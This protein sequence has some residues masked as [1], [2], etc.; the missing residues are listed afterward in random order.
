VSTIL[1]ALRRLE[2]EKQVQ[3]PRPLREQ[4]T[5]AAPTRRG[6]GW[7]AAMGAISAGVVVGALVFFLWPRLGAPDAAPSEA[8][9]AR[10]PASARVAPVRPPRAMPPPA[11]APGPAAR[12]ET[13]PGGG[14]ATLP[15]AALASR[16]EVVERMAPPARPPALPA[17]EPASP[18]PAVA[19]SPAPAPPVRSARRVTAPR[20]EAQ[21]EEGPRT[22]APAA[23]VVASAALPA[24]PAPVPRA[25]PAP[26]AEPVTARSD[27]PAAGSERS[28]PE[29]PSAPSKLVRTFVPGVLVVRTFW[30]PS[31][32]RRVAEIEVDGS[33]E[34][35]RLHEGDAVGPLVVR[36]IEP[37]GVVFLHD[38]VELR[39][40]VGAR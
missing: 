27:V 9:S 8:R 23:V 22:E 7:L 40:R 21:A 34:T 39:R 18:E 35:L 25:E 31:P 29:P 32:E 19:Q 38:E 6:L 13:S 12:T 20:P 30:H 5:T 17:P 10:A 14:S 33:P 37:S 11:V 3:L 15:P 2:E 1:K 36:E 28:S 4:V 26:R 24:P 16:V